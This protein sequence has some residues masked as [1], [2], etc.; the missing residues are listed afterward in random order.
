MTLDVTERCI[1]PQP[2]NSGRPWFQQ[3]FR[4]WVACNGWSA[5]YESF[6]GPTPE[7]ALARA[8]V[9]IRKTAEQNRQKHFERLSVLDA[10]IAALPK[11]G[12]P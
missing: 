5:A 7:W 6:Q 11:T 1:Y 9:Y 10:L 4:A 3:N 12:E 8:V 2:P